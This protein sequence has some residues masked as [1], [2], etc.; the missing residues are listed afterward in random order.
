[1]YDVVIVGAGWA[2]CAAAIA[3]KKQGA[4]VALIERTDMLLGTGLVGGIMRNN[5]RYTAAEEMI[6]MGAGELFKICD[7]NSRHTD[8]SFPG[9]RHASLYD[10][11]LVPNK[12]LDLLS[13][14][15]ISVYLNKR[16]IKAEVKDNEIL[17]VV[18]QQGED[19]EGKIFIDTTGTA[20][21][22]SNCIKYGNCC[23][24][25]IIRCP[26]F[27]GRVSLA[28][29]AGV[30]EYE[31][32]KDDGTV[33]AM[34][35]SC[36]LLKESLRKDLRDKLNQ[37]GIIIVP[38]PDNLKEDHLSKKACQQYAL[39]EFK[40]NLIILDTGHAKLMSPFFPIEKLRKIEG[41]ENVRF[42]DPYAGGMGNSMRFFDM[43]PRDNK[44]HVR[45]I[46][47]L[48]C[49]G[50]K[51]GPLVGHTEAIVT[52]T[53]AGFN[54]AR[55][56]KDKRTITIPLD[57]AV[58]FGIAHVQ[59]EIENGRGMGLKFTFSGSV[60]FDKMKEMGLYTCNITEICDRVENAG[61]KD[62]F[63]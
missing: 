15:E 11:A 4:S 29:L 5:G 57:L 48:Y 63:K 30:K 44:L 50:E 62:V 43:C 2:G 3:A 36:K 47:N 53:L 14:L 38:I 46:K 10:V 59:N 27:G 17:N 8:I 56:A 1:M 23:A 32:K 39:T 58:G 19:F 35:G 21:P 42:E 40:D 51:A 31:G 22:M 6:A 33:G 7:D 61:L 24:M 37:D 12:V 34:S 52:G 13:E 26:S 45:D 16:I 54:A 55:Q 9:H 20:G 60:L 25:C 18:S 28:K 49:A 41:F